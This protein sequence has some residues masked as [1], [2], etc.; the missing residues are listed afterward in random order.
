MWEINVRGE[1]TL[2]PLKHSKKMVLN[3]TKSG[4]LACKH[5]G[6]TLSAI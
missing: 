1:N 4:S 6:I 5:R 3:S 2:N